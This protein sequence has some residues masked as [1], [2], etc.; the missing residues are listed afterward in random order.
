MY[1]TLITVTQFAVS[2]ILSALAAYLGLWL[3]ERA[4]KEIDEWHEIQGGNVAIGVTLAAVVV[5]L[6]LI[7]RPAVT[8]V[9]PV[10]GGKLNPD[11]A[12]GLLPVF[13]LG[14]ILARSLLGLVM[15]A[16]AILFA[17]WLFF[18]LTRN[19][20]ELAE[21]RNGNSAVA[22]MLSGVILAVSLLIS[23]V[24]ESI[25]DTLFNIIWR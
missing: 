21:L 13:A 3:F 20:D 2:I 25:T 16:A 15:G 8:G 12:P 17:L 11:V 14:L 4:T 5:G 7:L 24:V 19:L 9:L 10:V 23:P 18:R 22:A 1:I 6:A